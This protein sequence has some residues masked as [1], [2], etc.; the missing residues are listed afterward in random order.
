MVSKRDAKGY[1]TNI[2]DGEKADSSENLTTRLS[3]QYLPTDDLTVDLVANT[4][5]SE[6]NIATYAQSQL[7]ALPGPFVS[8]I[9][10][11]DPFEQRDGFSDAIEANKVAYDDPSYTKLKSK[12]LMLSLNWDLGDVTLDSIT[13]YRTVDIKS[14]QDSDA[15][16]NGSSYASSSGGL[17]LVNNVTHTDA[18]QY[19]QELRLSSAIDGSLLWTAGIFYIHEDIDFDIVI[20]NTQGGPPVPLS[21]AV[22]A[23]PFIPPFTGFSGTTADFVASESVDA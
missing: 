21:G 10:G 20:N 16:P 8:P 19:S 23:P 17:S 9:Y 14:A 15:Q 1:A 2:V 3:L 18:D 5:D 7:M 11:D 4:S 6:M 22:L 13:G 12:D